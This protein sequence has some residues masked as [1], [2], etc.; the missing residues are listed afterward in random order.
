MEVVSYGLL[1]A[2][3]P[4][5]ELKDLEKSLRSYDFSAALKTL[6]SFEIPNAEI[7]GARHQGGE[8][9]RE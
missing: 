9:D 2:G 3:S 8:H 5:G 4:E 6:R 7:S 1:K